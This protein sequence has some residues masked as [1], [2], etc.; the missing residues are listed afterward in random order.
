[1]ARPTL[2]KNLATQRQIVAKI[3]PVAGATGSSDFPRLL[4]AG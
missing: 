3:K 1:M 2:F 4:Y